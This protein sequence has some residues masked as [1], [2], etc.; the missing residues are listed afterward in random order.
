MKKLNFLLLTLPLLMLTQGA[1]AEITGSGTSSDPY[2]LSTA[3][4]WNTFAAE[5]NSATYWASGVYIKMGANIGIVTTWAGTGNGTSSANGFKGIFDGCGYTLTVN[6]TA[7][8]RACAPFRYIQGATIQNLHVNGTINIGNYQNGGGIVGMAF[9]GTNNIKNCWS[10]V[11]IRTNRTDT[12]T[13]AGIVAYGYQGTTNIENC[14]FDGSLEGT[15]SATNCCGIFAYSNSATITVKNCFF[16]PTNFSCSSTNSYYTARTNHGS[17]T[18]TN[19]YYSTKNCTPTASSN[20][21]TEATNPMLATGE[22]CYKLNGSSS[23][24]PVWHQTIGTDESPILDT[25]HGTV[26]LK[27]NFLCDGVTPKEGG[28]VEYSND[29]N[30][31]IVDD[32]TYSNGLCSVC[33][34]SVDANYLVNGKFP[35]SNTAQMINFGKAINNADASLSGYL[36]TNIDMNGQTWTGMSSFAGTFDGGNFTISNLAA[37]LCMTTA[38]GVTI[39]NLT[40]E[41]ALTGTQEQFGA[42]ICEHKSGALTIEDCTNA[43]VITKGKNRTAGFVGAATKGTVTITNCRNIANIT[44]LI[45]NASGIIADIL[46]NVTST[47]LTNCKNT[48]DIKGSGSNSVQIAGLVGTC[49]SGNGSTITLTNCSNE[50]NIS[51]GKNS[52]SNSNVGGL[53]GW[54]NETNKTLTLTNCTNTGSVTATGN[55]IGGLIGQAGPGSTVNIIGCENGGTV[56]STS[57][58][59]TGGFIGETYNINISES[60]KN[61]GK[62]TATDARAGGFIGSV[63]D[64]AIVSISNSENLGEVSSSSEQVGGFVGRLQTGTTLTLENCVNGATLTGTHGVGGMLGQ[65]NSDTGGDISMT[66][67]SNTGNITTTATSGDS[68]AGGMIGFIYSVSNAT[69]TKCWNEGAIDASSKYSGGILGSR[70]SGTVT[71]TSCYNTG[72]ITDN[73]SASAIVGYGAATINNCWNSGTVTTSFS[74]GTCTDCYDLNSESTGVTQ[75][76]SDQITNGDLCYKLNGDQSTI[77][78]RQNIDNGETIDAH[79]VLAANGQVYQIATS[80]ENGYYSNT[81]TNPTLA[82]V[83]LIDN[84]NYAA[85]TDFTASTITYSRNMSNAWGTICLPFEIESNDDV[86]YYTTG[87]INGDVLTLTSTETVPAGT[88][89]IFKM[90]NGSGTYSVTGNDVGV[91]S[92]VQTETDNSDEINLVGVFEKT[93]FEDVTTDNA[94]EYYY[95]SNNKFMH[96]TRKLTI[97]PFRAYFTTAKSSTPSNGFSIAVNDDITAISAL[98]GEG[99]VTVEAIYTVDGKQLRDLQQGLNIVKLSNGKVQKIL[100]K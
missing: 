31:S 58:G 79:P 26:Y 97:N 51:G 13:S 82:S 83:T 50:G 80:G 29:P 57:L 16:M 14:L 34:A 55:K 95:I 66:G 22:L 18:I 73:T 3:E 35:I 88:P 43:T 44:S 9:N 54:L 72:D 32:H 62:V 59:Y 30:A 5:A 64:G 45:T 69:I 39:K 71:I 27:G 7:T 12:S 36:T 42:F 24:S 23:E 92:T 8:G 99:E 2:V 100:V 91:K 84:E 67:C 10:S 28:I 15:T 20:G 61:T 49:R 37:P 46:A 6:Y 76:T 87:E 1:R 68:R 4:D 53:L 75:V 86:V 33:E 78:W 60:S 21:D 52:N 89:A 17:V 40:L 94:N 11:T 93:I 98:T 56:S 90:Q 70:N 47:T 38:G 96:A 63:T 41:G 25:T 48:A 19:C 81:A 74:T 85:T 65:I 77:T